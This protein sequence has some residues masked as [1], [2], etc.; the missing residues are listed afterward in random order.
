MPPESGQERLIIEGFLD[1]ESFRSVST[2]NLVGTLDVQPYRSNIITAGVIS[3]AEPAATST[4]A[5]RSSPIR[6]RFRW[7]PKGNGWSWRFCVMFPGAE[8]RLPTPGS[9]AGD[10]WILESGRRR[11]GTSGGGFL[12]IVM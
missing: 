3:V 4:S 12:F 5:A 6:L 8:V 1:D 11:R 9:S 2:F 7:R 10:V